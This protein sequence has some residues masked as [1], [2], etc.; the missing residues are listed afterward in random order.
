MHQHGPNCRH[1]HGHGGHNHGH[2]HGGGFAGPAADLSP[3]EYF[4]KLK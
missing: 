3:D 2:S 4:S 1:G